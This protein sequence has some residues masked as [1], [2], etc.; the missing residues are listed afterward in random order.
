MT[1]LDRQVCRSIIISFSFTMAIVSYALIGWGLD[2]ESAMIAGGVLGFMM[3]LA[4]AHATAFK[5]EREQRQ[6]DRDRNQP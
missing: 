3:C 5:V 4:A 1:D 2:A 6:A